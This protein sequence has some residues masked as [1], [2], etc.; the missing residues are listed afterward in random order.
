M[1]ATE[2]QTLMENIRRD[3]LPAVLRGKPYTPNNKLYT[4]NYKPYTPNN[5]P[6]TL[7]SNPYIPNNKPYILNPKH[8]TLIINPEP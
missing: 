7:N 8:Y 3:V 2:L 4:L 5:K 1:S 6:Y